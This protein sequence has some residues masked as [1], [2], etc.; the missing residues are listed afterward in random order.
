MRS[1]SLDLPMLSELCKLVCMHRQ[2]SYAAKT[3]A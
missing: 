3:F 2:M 1:F